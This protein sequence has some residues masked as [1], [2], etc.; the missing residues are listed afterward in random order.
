MWSLLLNPKVYIPVIAGIA[1]LLIVWIVF[2]MGRSYE[3]SRGLQ[4]TIDAI[5][6]R[7]K[8][9]GTVST[10]DSKTLCDKL[11]GRWVSERCE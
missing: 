11:G 4:A 2:E 7:D 5:Q 6:E 9:N 10:Y 1:V 8:I 3:K